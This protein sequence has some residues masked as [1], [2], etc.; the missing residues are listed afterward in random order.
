[1]AKT[2]F[3][4]LPEGYRLPFDRILSSGNRYVHARLRRNRFFVS[5]RQRSNLKTF[6][7]LKAIATGWH[8]LTSEQRI[9]WQEAGAVRGLLGWQLYI[10]DKCIRYRY[11]IPGET[12]PSLLWQTWVGHLFVEHPAKEIMLKQS[13][14]VQYF[15]KVKII[16]KKTA[17]Q[18]IS[19][20]E[21]FHLPLTIGLS[22]RSNLAVVGDNP[23]VRFFARVYSS[24]QGQ[25]LNNDEEI[26]I[27]LVS[28]WDKDELLIPD[29]FGEAYGYD[30]FIH[31]KD[32]AGFLDFDNVRA[33]HSGGNWARDSYCEDI[34]QTFT[35]AF[36]NV[37][38]YWEPIILPTG[39]GFDSVYPG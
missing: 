32:V 3:L 34:A 23:Q 16:G 36:K 21:F 8:S 27:P 9:A 20:T 11:E 33:E 26:N 37:K 7:L 38:P 5:R 15:D 13:H 18:I 25:T 39:A 31:L 1:M 22:Y 14:P 4:D 29:V 12:T 24:Y 19:V 6:S 17:Q 2:G 35:G 28:D 10:Q 30:L